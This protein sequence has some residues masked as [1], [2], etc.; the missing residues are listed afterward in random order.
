MAEED[1]LR[2]SREEL[3]RLS[4]IQKVLRKELKQ[5]KAAELLGVSIRQIK[6]LAK[7]VRR[8]G[9]K[10]IIHRL[11]GKES[12]RKYE[13]GFKEKV[14]KIYERRYVGFGPTLAMEKLQE[15]ENIC[16]SD[17][18]LRKWLMEE[19]ECEWRRRGR[20]HREWR[21]R[22]GYCGEMEQMDGSH[23]D[24]LEGRGPKL[25]LMAYIDDATG[26]PWGRFY[27]YEGTL[28]AMDS[29]RRYVEKYGFPQSVYLDKHT[30][31][32]C[33]R[34][35]TIEEDLRG[36]KPLSQFG[37]AL[38]ELEVELIHAHSP[39]AKG[40]IERIF[41]TFQD[42]L[43]KEL[44][45][46]GV[47]DKEGANNF[48][49]S[50]LPKYYKR[51]GVIAREKANL[52]REV[53]KGLDL[54]RILCIKESRVL[55]NDWT[56]SYEAKLYQILDSVK[57]KKVSIEERCDGSMHLYAGN[58]EIAFR[59]IKE[60]PKKIRELKRTEW[61]LEIKTRKKNIPNKDHPWRKFNYGFYSSKSKRIKLRENKILENAA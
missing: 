40:R 15:R 61:P 17:E 1:I 29:F 35:A 60:R 30:T 28:P 26:R 25:V 27:D 16:L 10:G 5:K 46:A 36:E 7:R 24:W 3:K 44:R 32:K 37:R 22:K 47:K 45:L 6:R 38:C 21:E 18:T 59:E 43:V 57:A 13:D 42:R 53:P 9:E 12:N 56:V 58:H 14:L 48:L 34:E 8:E 23:H 33:P 31:Y 20:S 2:M 39:Q 19:G 11:R 51:F 49:E 55:R 50:Y 41:R 52:H 54:D 4:V